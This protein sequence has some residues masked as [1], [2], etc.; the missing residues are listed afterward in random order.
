MCRLALFCQVMSPNRQAEP[1][2]DEG[3]AHLVVRSL[4]LRLPSGQRLEPHAHPWSQLVYATEGVLTVTT[5]R[6]AW[7]VPPQRAV[8]I[9]AGFVHEVRTTGRVRMRAVYLRP[10]FAELPHECCVIQVSPLLRELVLA[11]VG[12]GMLRDDAPVDVRLAG[13]L[14]DQ[15]Q[16]LP[17]APLQVRYPVDERARRVV[18]RVRMDLAASASIADLAIGS[19][20][21][22]RTIERLFRQE[23]GLSFGRWLQKVKALHALERLAVG[24]SVTAAGLAIGYESTSAFI[25]MFKRLLGTTPGAWFRREPATGKQSKAS[26]GRRAEG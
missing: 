12:R 22:A 8:W 13:V 26:P 10:G 23:T 14:A 16:D 6:G 20:A 15:I 5:D 9:P 24:D 18:E 3:E 17:F 25:A 7:V 1:T 2:I 19:G 4:A 11:I 21:S